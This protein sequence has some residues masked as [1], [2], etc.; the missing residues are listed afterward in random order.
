MDLQPRRL[1]IS[2]AMVPRLAL[3]QGVYYTATGLWGLLHDRSFQKVT[4][5]KTDVWL[6]KT[7]SV[8]VVSIGTALT[9]AG[10]GRRGTVETRLLAASSASGLMAI[11]CYYVCR[12]RISPIYLLDAAVELGLL[13]GWAK[14]WRDRISS[15]SQN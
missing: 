2:R 11:D 12:R 13:A 1:S 10:L 4:G 15:N 8:L 3:F 14:G 7:V 5:P 6:V 9:W